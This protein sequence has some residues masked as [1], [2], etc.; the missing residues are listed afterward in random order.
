[1]ANPFQLRHRK[2][3]LQDI[4]NR[5]NDVELEVNWNGKVK[6]NKYIKLVI[7]G[8]EAIISHD[9]LWTIIFMLS[10]ID[11]QLDMLPTYEQRIKHYETI[12]NL[13]AKNDIRKGDLY[14]VHLTIAENPKTGQLSIRP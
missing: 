9:H 10:K 11:K 12:V 5:G 3:S 13:V 4:A 7:G 8:K 1:M 6:D 2:F 14:G